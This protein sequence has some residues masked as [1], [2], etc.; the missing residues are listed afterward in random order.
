MSE[1]TSSLIAAITIVILGIISF[2][3]MIYFALY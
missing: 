2:G 3:A 1:D